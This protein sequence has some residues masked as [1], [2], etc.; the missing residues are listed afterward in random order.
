MELLKEIRG[1]FASAEYGAK[2]IEALPDEYPAIAI[3]NNEGY[4]VAIEFNQEKDITEKFANCR[5]YTEYLIINGVEN[6]YLILSSML[7]ELRYEFSTVCAQF[8]DPGENG[9]YRKQLLDDPLTWWKQWR[10]LLGNK[11][12][13]N[14]SYNVIAEM[15]VLDKVLKEHPSAQWSAIESGSHD[16]EC[17]DFCCEVKSTVKRYGATVSISGQHQ[18][19]KEKSEEL[20]LYFCRMEKS[21]SGISINDMAKRLISDGY[22]ENLLEQQLF[23]MGYEKGAS[24][25]DSRYKILEKRKYLVDDKFPKITK[26]SFKNNYI[27]ESVIRIVYSVDLEGLDYS[28]W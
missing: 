26:E 12:S 20:Y 17:D 25:R 3:R 28:E 18:L 1:W 9:D 13:N 7:N 19:Q 23:Y 6:K 2:I 16:I 24:I 4:G 11:I 14:K 15:L 5:I 27:P 10:E 21:K 22:N 8:V